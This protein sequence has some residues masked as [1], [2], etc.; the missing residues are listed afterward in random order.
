[1]LRKYGVFP[2]FPGWLMSMIAPTWAIASSSST[3][4]ITGSPGKWPWKNGSFIVQF[5]SPTMRFP[6][7]YSVIRSTSKN[8]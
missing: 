1:M 7:V 2:W 8:G 6:S 5:F 3:P 4:G